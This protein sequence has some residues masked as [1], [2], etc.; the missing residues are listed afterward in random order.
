[1][2]FSTLLAFNSANYFSGK[3]NPRVHIAGEDSKLM[4]L[5]KQSEVKVVSL[6]SM[7]TSKYFTFILSQNFP[8]VLLIAPQFLLFY[9]CFQSFLSASSLL[10]V[11]N[12][13]LSFCVWFLVH[14]ITIHLSNMII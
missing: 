9:F 6:T 14:F 12:S 8:Y 7:H 5:V 11:H 4:L 10:P 1:M 3:Y 2:S 13:S